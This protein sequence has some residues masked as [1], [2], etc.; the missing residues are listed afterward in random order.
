MSKTNEKRPFVS[1]SEWE[2]TQE[3]ARKELARLSRI[4]LIGDDEYEDDGYDTYKAREDVSRF[5]SSRLPW[6]D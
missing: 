6:I 3:L 1:Q 4:G 5:V 2:I